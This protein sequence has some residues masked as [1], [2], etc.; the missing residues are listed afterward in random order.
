M[1]GKTLLE[2]VTPLG[3][4]RTLVAGAS[5]ATA[6][7]RPLDRHHD[8]ARPT[9]SRCTVHTMKEHQPIW[10]GLAAGACATM[11]SR[12]LT[13][14][15][16]GPGAGGGRCFRC[17]ERGA[18][19]WHGSARHPHAGNGAVHWLTQPAAGD[20]SGLLTAAPWGPSLFPQ[21]PWT[22]SSPGC[23][24]KAPARMLASP[25]STPRR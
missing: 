6:G 18:V 25:S 22:R 16:G 21:I 14:A 10:H 2:G 4:T 9:E 17:R 19:D 11:S 23:R 12:T 24:F 8:V 15:R 13:C 5:T 20:G 1:P 7:P 3:P